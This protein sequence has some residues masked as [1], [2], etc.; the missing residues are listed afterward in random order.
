MVKPMTEIELNERIERLLIEQEHSCIVKQGDTAYRR[1]M[2][3]RKNDKRM[4]EISR[5]YI[6]RGPFVSWGFEGT[7]LYHSGYYIKYPRNSKEKKLLKRLTNKRCRRAAELPSKGL[8]Y[9]RLLDYWWIL[10]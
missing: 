6:P 2:R 4:H 7:T 8:Q 10:D 3:V 9:R 1:E 5:H